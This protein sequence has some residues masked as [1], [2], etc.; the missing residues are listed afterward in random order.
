MVDQDKSHLHGRHVSENPLTPTVSSPP[1]SP[2]L[3]GNLFNRKKGK[4]MEYEN[5]QRNKPHYF[6]LNC[7]PPLSFAVDVVHSQAA[8]HFCDG[9]GINTIKPTV[10]Q[11]EKQK[12]TL[13][14]FNEKEASRLMHKWILPLCFLSLRICIQ[15]LS[16]SVLIEK[17][18]IAT[19]CST[20][21]RKGKESQRKYI[22]IL[23]SNIVMMTKMMIFSQSTTPIS[24]SQLFWSQGC[25]ICWN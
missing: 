3:L 23:E 4:K 14:W 6:F 11:I 1:D 22:K 13:L 12:E 21:W 24:A 16:P 8:V 15:P 5:I 20:P 2:L 7:T 17:T 19:L 9:Q 25:S 10:F 18:N